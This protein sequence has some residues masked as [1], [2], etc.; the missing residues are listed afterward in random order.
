MFHTASEDFTAA[1]IIM[2]QQTAR[3]RGLTGG[4]VLE[5]DKGW[6]PVDSITVGDMVHSFDGGLR[7]VQAV[8]RHFATQAALDA[9]GVRPLQ[10][11]GGVLNACSDLLV[12]P[13]QGVLCPV[14]AA[15]NGG[16]DHRLY[17]ARD[18]V[19]RPGVTRRQVRQPLALVELGFAEEEV[20]WANTGVLLHCPAA[21]AWDASW[22][23]Y[24]AEGATDPA[25]AS[26]ARALKA[27]ALVDA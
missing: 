11:S 20:I 2:P 16:Q 14:D 26:S 1:Q 18:L 25:P 21:G 8:R 10:I 7:R 23:I 15:R 27:P 5:T 3:L 12:L 4:T 19:Q 9:H 13:D 24:A 6:R 22:G 17:A